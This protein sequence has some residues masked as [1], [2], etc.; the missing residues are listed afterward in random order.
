MDFSIKEVP[1]GKGENFRDKEYV[2]LAEK[3]RCA[4]FRNAFNVVLHDGRRKR[5]SFYI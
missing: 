5:V 4:K 2:L 1:R 3:S